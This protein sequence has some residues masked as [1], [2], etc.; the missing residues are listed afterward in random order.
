MGKTESAFYKHQGEADQVLYLSEIEL[1][2][3][4]EGEVCVEVKASGINPSDVKKRLGL[5][6][7]MGS[8]RV[9]PHSD[10]AGIITK[11]GRGVPKSR[12]GE[13]VWIYEGQHDR[14]WGTASRVIH[15]E[16]SKCIE[17]PDN[18]SFLEGACIGIPMMTAHRALFFRGEVKNKTLLIT[19]V[20]SKVGYY[21]LAM[22]KFYGA[23]VLA[24]TSQEETE[25]FYDLGANRVFNYKEDYI[26][27]MKE[28]LKEEKI[29]HVIDVEFGENISDY[30]ELLADFGVIT[31]YS[32]SKKAYPE[33][34]FNELMFK[35][36]TIY[37]FFVYSLDQKMKEDAVTAI[38]EVLKKGIVHRANHVYALE[39][40]A[41][42]HRA[43]EKGV[44]GSVIIDMTKE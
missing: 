29:D 16:S 26:S 6:G 21:A 5:R 41:K 32:S 44:L 11:V 33:I 12:I 10:G 17:L 22:A 2:E 13:R 7:E 25:H 3:L 4:K 38:N 31:T 9:I 35:N 27:Q 42:A 43:V 34:P 23:K 19:G 20:Q 37:P 8:E 18:V 14:N 39:E 40:I 1:P 28:Y 15:I 24:T 30:V 36:I